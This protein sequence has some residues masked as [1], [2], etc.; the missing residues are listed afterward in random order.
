MPVVHQKNI[1]VAQQDLDELDHVNNVRYLQ[2]VQ[3]IAREH[4]QLLAPT[5]A[6]EQFVWVALNHHIEYQGQAFLGDNVHIKTWATLKGITS[7]RFVEMYVDE[8]VINK[9]TTTWCML[10]ATTK[11]PARIPQ[12]V[13]DAFA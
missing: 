6:L 8:K 12:E 4:W 1:I 2:W 10:N 9:T 5:S 11:K 13:L 3:D 7:T